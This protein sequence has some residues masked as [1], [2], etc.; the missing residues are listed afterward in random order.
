LR[1]RNHASNA[2][3]VGDCVN[4]SKG[5]LCRNIGPL[6]ACIGCGGLCVTVYSQM[7]VIA[8]GLAI[9]TTLALV[10]PSNLLLQAP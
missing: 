2:G 8:L 6:H 3:K 9:R 10:P 7:F 5:S 1:R 4:E